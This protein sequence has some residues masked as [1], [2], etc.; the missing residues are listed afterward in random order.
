MALDD[1]PFVPPHDGFFAT[2]AFTDRA[3]EFVG[4]AKQKEQPFFLYLAYNAPHWPL[5]ARPAEI[6]KHKGRYDAGWQA[7]RGAAQAAARAEDHRPT[8]RR[9]RRW[10]AATST[11][12]DKL[13][14]AQRRE[15]ALRMEIYAA[16]VTHA[17]RE[18]RQARRRAVAV[19]ACR[20]TRWCC[21][22]SDNGGA[23]EDPHR[24][25]PTPD[26]PLGSRDSSGAT[27]AR[28]RPSAT[29]RGACTR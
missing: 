8:T 24:G 22:L 11:P 7:I 26:A 17:G 9:W 27:P 13:S 16:M 21:S 25:E 29:R 20:R 12:W 2:D 19:S 4:E 5:H 1:K 15:W 14:D 23:A 18:R 6:A 3:I 28:G 10:T